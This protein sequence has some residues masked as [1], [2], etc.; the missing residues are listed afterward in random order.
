MDYFK[1]KLDVAYCEYT[2]EEKQ[3]LSLIK[4]ERWYKQ[5]GYEDLVLVDSEI[6]D[7]L[8]DKLKQYIE[9]VNSKDES[10]FTK[11]EKIEKRILAYGRRISEII[12]HRF[13]PDENNIWEEEIKGMYDLYNS[14]FKDMHPTVCPLCNKI[15]THK[16]SHYHFYMHEK[17]CE[18]LRKLI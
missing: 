6:I 17:E 5:R 9:E 1:D 12:N 11:L 2:R 4:R 15:T 10:I 7:R 3:E 16:N 8:R 13:R 18:K 14:L